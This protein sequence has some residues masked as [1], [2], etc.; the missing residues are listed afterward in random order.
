VSGPPGFKDPPPPGG[1]KGKDKDKEYGEKREG[2]AKKLD[3][4]QKKEEKAENQSVNQPEKPAPI[5]R[6]IIRTGEM[7]FETESFDKAVD[8]IDKLIDAIP[9][10]GGFVATV[11]SDKLPN[12]KMRGSVVVRVRPE[13]LDKFLKDL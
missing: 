1:D 3:E 8:T 2:E 6:K 9:N 11:N 10:K 12:G 7:E 13:F 4:A 5:G